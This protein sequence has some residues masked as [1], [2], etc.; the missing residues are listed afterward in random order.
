MKSYDNLVKNIDSF[1]RKYYL[2]KIIRG[3]LIFAVG[4]LLTLFVFILLEYVFEFKPI[5]RKAIFFSYIFLNGAFL[6]LRIIIPWMY[7][8][9]IVKGMSKEEAAIYIGSKNAPVSDR[10]LN[11][12]QLKKKYDQ[13]KSDLIFASI[14]Q[15]LLKLKNQ[16]FS[17]V[18]KLRRNLRVVPY[19]LLLVFSFLSMYFFTPDFIKKPIERI[20]HYSQEYKPFIF[21]N[22]SDIISIEEGQDVQIQVRLVGD[23]IPKD[24]YIESSFGTF[25]MK[26]NK[27]NEFLYTFKKVKNNFTYR[28]KSQAYYSSNYAVNVYGKSFI[29]EFSLEVQYPKYLELPNKKIIDFNTITLP[30]GSTIVTH[31]KTKNTT[32]NTLEIGNKKQGFNNEIK[33]QFTLEESIAMTLVINNRSSQKKDT[34]SKK[35]DVLKDLYPTITVFTEQDSVQKGVFYFNGT[36]EDDY[37]VKALNFYFK[38]N[39]ED[40]QK[41]NVTEAKGLKMNYQYAVDFY[42]LELKTE[43]N[44]EY[45]FTVSDN[46]G[47]NGSKTTSSKKQV[48]VVPSLKEIIEKR[49]ENQNAV[50]TTLSDLSKETEELQKQIEQFKKEVSQ[51]KNNKWNNL[52][53]LKRIQNSYEKLN[54]SIQNSQEKLK[55]SFEEKE[56]L[57]PA[58]QEILEKQELLEKMLDELM[59]EEMKNLLEELEKLLQNEEKD[60]I[61]EKME[62]LELSNKDI[63]EKLDRS[64][65][66]LKKNKVNE[67]IDNIEDQLQELAKKQEEL[68]ETNKEEELQKQDE[69]NEDFKE[70]QKELEELEK[71]NKDL[72][73]PLSLPQTEE[74]SKDIK[75]SLEEAKEMLNQGKSNKANKSQKSSSEK[76]KDL[77]NQLNALQNQSN[78]KQ[79][80]EDMEA[81]RSLLQNIV[82]L[83]LNQ[84]SV[85]QDFSNLNTGSAGF[86]LKGRDQK[87]LIDDSEMIIDSL[88]QLAKRQPSIASFIDKEVGILRHNFPLIIKGIGSRNKREINKTQQKSMTSLNN[89]AL[90][91]NESL[92]SM[93]QQMN[94]QM[95]G[96]GQCSNPGGGRPKPSPG[97]MEDMK[98][99]LKKQLEQM[100]KGQQPGGEKPDKG[101][102]KGGLG[103][104]N[105][106]ISK[107]AAEQS[108][109]RKKLEEIRNNLKDKKG[110]VGDQLNELLKELEKQQKDLVNKNF[111]NTLNRQK[112]ILTRLLESEK[113]MNERGQEEKRESKTA[114]NNNQGNKIQIQEYNKTKLKNIEDI[115]SINPSYIKYYKEKANEYLNN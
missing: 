16:N 32:D 47:V 86:V 103:L 13:D 112:E 3:L 15:N 50:E 33:E 35:I 80:Q 36:I 67:K 83:S 40:V 66:L 89:L 92:Q 18:I 25:L 1:I 39:E 46:D 72:E 43:D 99:M 77:A 53:K 44:I 30:E 34:L 114:K 57:S 87:K 42:K 81:I 75:E 48:F 64:L 51:E 97:G 19:L 7:Y 58:D 90:L 94:S 9:R 84:E 22:I 63:K 73:R 62:E 14:E 8:S 23:K 69:I 101:E 6:I 110:G 52:E 98:E 26:K 88:L 45:W 78:Q 24:V 108:A 60:L 55:N 31:I 109:I 38:K 10:L 96:S 113:A 21:E 12:V 93:Q 2:N 79:Q 104:G 85:L 59:D 5:Y 28:F 76:M 82:L 107:M 61:K 20:V 29:S 70:I 100:K 106:E 105:K 111:N 74:K 11:T 27:K 41:L 65:E 71:L 4:L 56:K 49:E 115:R 68:A 91:L 37:G 17:S 95:E 102:G 54:E